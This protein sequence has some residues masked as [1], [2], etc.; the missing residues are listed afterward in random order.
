MYDGCVCRCAELNRLVDEL[1]LENKALDRQ[2][3]EAVN[4]K[5]QLSE[6]LDAWQVLVAVVVLYCNFLKT[7]TTTNCYYYYY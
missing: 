4:Q 6:Q 1:R 2:I 7:V 5:L 3:L